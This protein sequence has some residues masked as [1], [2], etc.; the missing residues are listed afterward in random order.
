MGERRIAI[1]Q[2]CRGRRACRPWRAFCA[3][4]QRLIRCKMQSGS[5][6]GRQSGNQSPPPT[7]RA[8]SG[9]RSLWNSAWRICRTH[10]GKLSRLHFRVRRLGSLTCTSCISGE[11]DLLCVALH[12]PASSM[13]AWSACANWRFVA[14]R[15]SIRGNATTMAI[16]NSWFRSTQTRVKSWCRCQLTA[17]CTSSAVMTAARGRVS[18]GWN[19]PTSSG[20]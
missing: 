15:P 11:V 7:L 10:C 5:L 17:C 8:I 1:S 9:R 20:T 19:P 13:M 14:K 18:A 3:A 12:L 16:P 6:L 4:S 2:N